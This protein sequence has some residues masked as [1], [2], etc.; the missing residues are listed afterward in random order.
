VSCIVLRLV[1][2]TVRKKRSWFLSAFTFNYK[3]VAPNLK[4]LLIH[5]VSLPR[6]AHIVYFHDRDA[7]S[8]LVVREYMVHA[9]TS[10]YVRLMEHY[11]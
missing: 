9:V 4:D 10:A 11:A 8:R 3:P 5:L 7:V 1:S 2:L 6:C